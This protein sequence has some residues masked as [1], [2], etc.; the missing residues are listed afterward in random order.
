MEALLPS[1]AGCQ[2]RR[3][4]RALPA[5]TRAREGLETLPGFPSQRHP[6]PSWTRKARPK[7][8]VP[9]SRGP[10][11]GFAR[12]GPSREGLETLLGFPLQLGAPGASPPRPSE[13]SGEAG[14]REGADGRAPL[15]QMARLTAPK[16]PYPARSSP[17]PV[18]AARPASVSWASP[19][20]CRAPPESAPIQPSRSPASRSRPGT[21]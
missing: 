16:T 20:A 17:A 11:A 1:S 10:P 6:S 21:P 14:G 15:S 4:R 12:R 13:A 8:D 5:G 9:G 7:M 18:P 19:P 3:R 2:P